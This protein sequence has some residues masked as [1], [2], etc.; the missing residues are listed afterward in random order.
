MKNKIKN[1]ENSEI[2]DTE[3]LEK[4]EL[5]SWYQ[6]NK[7][8]LPWRETRE[9]YAIWVSE[10]MLQQ[11]QVDTVIPYYKRFL[12][13]LPLVGRLAEAT[14]EEV[15]KLWEGMG[16]YN[17]VRNLHK[18]AKQV[19]EQHQG[20]I[21]RDLDNF[22]K[23]PGVGDYISAA[24]LSIS[25][26]TPLPVVD[27][28]V[29]RVCTR[30]WGIE[31]DIKSTSTRKYIFDTLKPLISI[32]TPGDFNQA[33]MELGAMVCKPGKPMCEKCPLRKGCYAYNTNTIGKF[34]VKS[35]RAKV[36]EYKVSIA[37]IRDN[38]KIY[39]QK[40]PSGG[41]LG[42][43]WEFPGGK[44]RKRETPE[45]ALQREC[46]EELN[47]EV[48]I[49][50]ELKTLRHVYSHFK[51]LLSVFICQADRKKIQPLHQPYKWIKIS[52]LSIYPFPGANHKFFP[53]LIQYFQKNTQSQ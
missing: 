51:I 13:K 2:K 30:I 23:L 11:T 34:P 52:D 29:L 48:E 39:I 35:P 3:R 43:M 46:Q 47:A 26:N 21:P 40:R 42:G 19:K 10:V 27:G 7:R 22:R 31:K 33:M 4:D 45:Q 1:N 12:E 16:Y 18:A 6:H 53:D 8:S 14:E 36:P 38:N 44:A 32:E 20:Q 5:L 41:H 17:R 9:I 37:V 50:A 49:V 25:E 28:N 15:L 24:V